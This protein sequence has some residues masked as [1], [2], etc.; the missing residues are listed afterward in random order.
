MKVIRKP[1]GS[2]KKI[3]FYNTTVTALLQHNEQYLVKMRDVFRVFYENRDEVALL[4]RPHPLFAST[5]EAMRPGLGE[6][7]REI[8]K[9]YRE[10][11]WGIYD[12][13]S[14]MD[15]AVA[16]SDAYYGDWSSVAWL[17]QIIEKPIM[18]QNVDVLS[19]QDDS[20]SIADIVRYNDKLFILTRDTYS[21][22]EF[23][24]STQKT[25]WCGTAKKQINQ[26]F[27]CMTVCEGKI[28]IAPYEADIIPVYDIEKGEFEYILLRQPDGKRKNKY[29]HLCF[30]HQQRVFFLGGLD[31]TMLSINVQNGIVSEITDWMEEFE[32]REGQEAAIMTHTDKC[33]IEDCFWVALQGKNV[34]L[35]YNMITGNYQFWHV[36]DVQ[37][38]YTTINYD[39]RY[40]WLSGNRKIIIRWEKETGNVKGITHFPD[41]FEMGDGEQEA[42]FYCCYPWNDAFYFAPWNSNMLIE[43]NPGTGMMKNVLKNSDASFF[44][45]EL[46]EMNDSELY[47]EMM[48]K[49]GI[50]KSSYTINRKNGYCCHSIKADRKDEINC[51][52]ESTFVEENHSKYLNL[53]LVK[54]KLDEDLKERVS[55]VGQKI[56]GVVIER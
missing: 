42:L 8:V 38:Q 56:C 41:G 22:F 28:Y 17:Y 16:L 19:N 32:R 12:D 2:W 29:Y 26:I 14:D 11:G 43:L 37:I 53:F 52:M 35:Q 9:R 1:D 24:I 47:I 20:L 51:E 46:A 34:L 27:I 18:Y 40:F 25:K 30:N 50:R 31:S 3:I 5:I 36:G 48:D 23:D 39:G 10:D 7:Y 4:W 33:I 13:T 55:C 44:C 45:C 15:R 6:A 21:L 54:Q 49:K